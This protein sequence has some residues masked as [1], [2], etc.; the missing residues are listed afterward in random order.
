MENGIRRTEY[1]ERKNVFFDKKFD[2]Q[3]KFFIN[4]IKL[5]VVEKEILDRIL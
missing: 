5:L 1:G 3:N 4:G 2:K